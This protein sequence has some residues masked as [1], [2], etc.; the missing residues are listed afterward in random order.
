M[1]AK[2]GIIAPVPKNA[3]IAVLYFQCSTQNKYEFNHVRLYGIYSRSGVNI[4][5]FLKECLL[6]RDSEDPANSNPKLP[7]NR[8]YE[9]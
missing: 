1:N 8:S 3:M 6:I 5:M 7:E 9:Y 2:H 4:I